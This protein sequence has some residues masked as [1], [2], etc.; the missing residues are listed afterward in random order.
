MDFREANI[1]PA[2]I[3]IIIIIIFYRNLTKESGTGR[4]FS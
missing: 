2:F 1:E 3:I 4:R